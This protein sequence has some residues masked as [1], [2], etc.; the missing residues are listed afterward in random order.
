M[1]RYAGAYDF[2]NKQQFENTVDP[3]DIMKGYRADPTNKS[4]GK[5]GLE[6][7]PKRF[8][9]SDFYDIATGSAKGVPFGAPDISP[10]D[11]VNRVLVEGRGD[12][13]ANSYDFTNKKL[14]QLYGNILSVDPDNP[15][16]ATYATA[17][18]EKMDLAKRLGIPLSKAWIGTGKV[19]KN[20]GGDEYAARA[21]A[22]EYAADRPENAHLIDFVKRARAGELTPDE[23]KRA[24]IQR[25]EEAYKTIGSVHPKQFKRNLL[26]NLKDNRNA[27]ET[28][29]NLP[30]TLL[31][32]AAENM[33]REHHGIPQKP[34]GGI[35]V[36]YDPV[37]KGF[38]G[39]SPDAITLTQLITAKPEV[40]QVIARMIG[41]EPPPQ[42]QKSA[43]DKAKELYESTKK[44]IG[45]NSGGIAK[46]I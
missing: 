45:F 42:P 41:L 16:G 36:R 44:S 23:Y 13:G 43:L 28:V 33:Y 7:L 6:T 38:V 25:L 34:Y 22:H 32:N 8:S 5:T 1:T 14:A 27:Y 24:T 2:L 4:G 35:D 19:T 37:K 12:A 40:R 3:A 20:Y 17:M 31:A 18:R 39:P 10:R 9:L 29:S 21:A 15:G 11:L 26:E 30:H 46:L